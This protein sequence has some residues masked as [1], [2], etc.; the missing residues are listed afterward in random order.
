MQEALEGLLFGLQVAITPENL[1][2]AFAGALAGTILGIIPGIGPVA[3]AAIV[4][5]L[6]FTM[7]LT[8]ALIV[9]AAIYYGVAYG[10]STSAILLNIPGEVSS[11][12]T[13]L[14]GHKMTEKGQAGRA[15]GVAAVASFFA[16]V[17]SVLLVALASPF[18]ADLGLRFGPAEFFSVTM[19][20]S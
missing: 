6:T 4:L 18:F 11:V 3:G 16:A 12:V 14:D 2:A 10:S 5:Q 13:A 9:I 20:A 8:A 1:L 7:E 17:T 15:L 19:G